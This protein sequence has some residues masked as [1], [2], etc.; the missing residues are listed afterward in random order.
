MKSGLAASTIAYTDLHRYRSHLSGSAALC[1]V[2]DEEAGGKYGTKYLLEDPRWRSDCM[3]N[4][5]PGG[6]GTIRFAEKGT[7][8]LTFEVRTEGAHGA[9]TH[10]SEFSTY[11]P[12]TIYM[13]ISDL[14]RGKCL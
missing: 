11:R 5:E 8:R 9:Y 14:S 2:S 6:R 3:I 7:L 13:Y 4:P 12:L 10:R 1:A